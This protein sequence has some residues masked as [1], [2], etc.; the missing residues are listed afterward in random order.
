MENYYLCSKMVIDLLKL[1]EVSKPFK[2]GYEHDTEDYYIAVF[3][4]DKVEEQS[5]ILPKEEQSNFWCQELVEGTMD[6]SKIRMKSIKEKGFLIEIEDRIGLTSLPNVCMTL[7]GLSKRFNV[8]P[9]E[10]V[11]KYF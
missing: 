10:L 3:D 11:N 1:T 4:F 2:G 9:I 6:V 5:N 8:T 7:K